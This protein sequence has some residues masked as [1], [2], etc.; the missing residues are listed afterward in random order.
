M[1]RQYIQVSDEQRRLLVHLIQRNNYS[2]S[3]ASKAVDVPYDNAKAINRTFLKENRTRKIDYH[4]RQ[5]KTKHRR[6]QARQGS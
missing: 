5:Q 4:E 2:I 6:K 1:V 3:Q